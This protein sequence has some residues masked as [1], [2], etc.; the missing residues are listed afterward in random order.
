MTLGK[1]FIFSR[2]Q[3]GGSQLPPFFLFIGALVS[4][5]WSVI[6]SVV[7]ITIPYQIELRE[8]AA[9]VVT[10]ILSSRGNPYTFENQP[11]AMNIYG[12]GYNL[13]VLPFAALFGNTLLV[14]R[15]VTFAF[16]VLSAWTVFMA[17]YKMRKDVPLGLISAAF[18]MISLIA[19]GGIGAFPSAMGTF[20]FLASALIPFLRSYNKSSL[21]LSA[22]LA[23]MAFYTKPYFI[24]AFGIVAS[25]LFLFV[26]K[27]KGVIYA[28]FFLLLFAA[29]FVLVRSIFPL[30]FF[31][32]ILVNMSMSW[33]STAHLWNQLSNLFFGFWPILVVSIIFLAAERMDNKPELAQI[34]KRKDRANILDW[35]RPLFDY[36][37]DYCLYLFLCALLAFVFILGRHMGNDMNYAYQL[38]VPTYLCWFAGKIN[39]GKKFTAL[40]TLL[41]LF[42]LFSWQGVLL[43]PRMLEQKNSKEWAHFFS[44]VDSSSNILNSQIETS[45]VMRLGLTPIDAG[46]TIVYYLVKP[47]PDNL[48][49][50]ASY[51]SIVA[52]GF[53]YTKFI[54]QSIQAQKFDLV[55][56]V[57]EKG[58]FYHVK[59]LEDYYTPVDE[60]RLD[61]PQS[62]QAWTVLIWKPKTK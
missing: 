25:F 9:Q 42:N 58:A 59:R 43:D 46:Q 29:S 44:Y 23:L 17:V 30:Y 4:I 35:Q 16:I 14:H 6:F 52:D 38:L 49:V 51:E 61:M 27:K 2:S 56:S 57:K 12:L 37:F 26:S 22:L 33:L 15:A 53:K 10:Q 45:E 28:L 60:I 62:S 7:T 18:V 20:L 55:V 24:L 47:F 19:H 8:G 11:L 34:Q 5:L 50:N 3:S 1:A 39:F 54:D 32:T 21:V 31:N 48:L 40:F 36:T 13:A 41:I